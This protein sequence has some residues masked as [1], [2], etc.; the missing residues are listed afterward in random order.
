MEYENEVK[1]NRRCPRCNTVNCIRASVVILQHKLPKCA[2]C[3]YGLMDPAEAQKL[4]AQNPDI[5]V[6]A[7]EHERMLREEEALDEV[8]VSDGDDDDDQGF[9]PF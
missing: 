9:V 2:K 5:I 1:I 3:G 8:Y 7:Q 6:E 4:E